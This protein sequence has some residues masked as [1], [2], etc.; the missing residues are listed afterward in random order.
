MVWMHTRRLIVRK[1]ICERS[2]AAGFK[3]NWSK[4]VNAKSVF[5]V[6][7]SPSFMIIHMLPGDIFNNLPVGR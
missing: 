3:D 5:N 7:K 6:S 4:A 2:P 1:T